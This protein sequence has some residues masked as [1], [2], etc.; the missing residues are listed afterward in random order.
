MSAL[1]LAPGLDRAAE[2]NKLVGVVTE[3]G[4]QYAV[5]LIWHTACTPQALAAEARES[6]S[7]LQAGVL[8][9][10]PARD[11]GGVTQYGLGE[12]LLGHR[13]GLAALAP[14]IAAG[15]LNSLLAAWRTTGGA[16]VVIAIRDD[17][18]IVCDKAFAHESDAATAFLDHLTD[19]WTERI[20]PSH[21]SNPSTTDAPLASYLR[22]KKVLLQT[23][24]GA[25]N[26]VLRLGAVSLLTV[27]AA[28]GVLY[29]LK[30]QEKAQVPGKPVLHS[31]KASRPWAGAPR[32]LPALLACERAL[33]RDGF[34]LLSIP[35]WKLGE[36]GRCDGKSVRFGLV[37]TTGT[38]GWA[39]YAL[40]S[41][42]GDL[43][44]TGT[45]SA[46]TVS[47]PLPPAP[48]LEQLSD[49]P[50]LREALRYLQAQF[51]EAGVEL[52]GRLEHEPSDVLHVSFNVQ[53]DMLPFASV[54]EPIRNAVLREIT[55]DVLTDSW[56]VTAA[57][58][59]RPVSPTDP[60]LP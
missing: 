46:L 23:P 43:N 41:I 21:W 42:P 18:T 31:P 12:L 49:E 32:L 29:L 44:V 26:R 4:R 30:S 57:L 33:R 39:D 13:H 22:A 11:P 10:Y 34:G 20:C 2:E 50:P 24:R 19:E 25:R 40:R 58:Y 51:E 38:R 15:C 16:W 5:S 37:R 36:A 56:R 8:C 47:R 17:N 55:Y 54:F 53:G 35:G 6:A 14:S 45:H 59:P 60:A 1:N 52:D 9:L 7:R 28:G 48:V 27:L 3:S